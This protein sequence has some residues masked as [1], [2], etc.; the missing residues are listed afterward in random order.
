VAATKGAVSVLLTVPAPGRWLEQ[1]ARQ[2]LSDPGSP[3]AAGVEVASTCIADFLRI[4]AGIPVDGLL[5]DEGPTPHG[6]LTR[7]EAYRP[8]LNVAD[9]YGWPV[10]VRA[11]SAAA[12]P[13]G[14]VPGVAAWL[15][16]A[17]PDRSNGRWGIVAGA[18]FWD[19]AE[20]PREA[21]IVLAAVPVDADPAAVM[22]RVRALA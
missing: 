1:A 11:D 20:P 5:V 4:I 17:A 8:V 12:W 16:S 21:G 13:H 15:G 18:E 10:V 6:D 9:N 2:A 14:T 22:T 19:G 7:L 3:D